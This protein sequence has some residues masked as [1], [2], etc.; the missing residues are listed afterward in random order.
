[1]AHQ[2]WGEQGYGTAKPPASVPPV[3]GTP[4]AVAHHAPSHAAMPHAAMPQSAMRAATTDRE[5]TV[6]VLKAAFAE[7][8]LSAAEYGERFE[9]ASTAQ[10]YGQLA[11]LVADLPAGPMVAPQMVAPQMAVH[12]PPTF[13]PPPVLVPPPRPT[14]G[15]AVASLVLSL[16]GLGLPAVIAGHVAKDQIRRRNEDGDGMATVGL[17]LGYVECAFWSLLMLVVLAAGG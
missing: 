15:A 12:V 7:G 14:N 11:R 3:P 17:V 13:L 16:L 4:P 8:R 2:P 1:M 10:T 6:D 5:R 9:A